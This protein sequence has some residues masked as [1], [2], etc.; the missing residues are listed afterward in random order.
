MAIAG[1][2]GWVPWPAIGMCVTYRRLM[3]AAASEATTALTRSPM[4]K[5]VEARATATNGTP[6]ITDCIVMPNA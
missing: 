4:M 5:P 6:V 3:P 1:Q 2:S